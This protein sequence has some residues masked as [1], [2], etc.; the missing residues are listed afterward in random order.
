MPAKRNKEKGRGESR[1][2]GGREEREQDRGREAREAQM[3][4]NEICTARSV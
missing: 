2:E 3:L 1:I 4:G